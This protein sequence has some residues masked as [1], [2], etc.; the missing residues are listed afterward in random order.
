MTE[1]Q[2]ELLRQHVFDQ[3]GL[4]GAAFLLCGQSMSDESAKLIVHAVMPIDA[5]D[6][7]ERRRDGLVIKS[8]ALTRIA[9]LARNE[10][11]SIVFVHS[12]P[13]GAD[14]FSAQDDREEGRL[15]PFLQ[16]RVPGKIHGTL[17]LTK[18]SIV[19][20]L[21]MPDRQALDKTIAVGSRIRCWRA[22]SQV[23]SDFLDRQIRA[24]GKDIQSALSCLHIGI[25]G[26]G[27]TGSPVAEQLARLGV[28]MIS[29]FDGDT[30]EASN[31]NRVQG[32]HRADVGLYKVDIAK[33]NI[34]K[35]GL[36]TV[37]RAIPEHITTERSALA[38]RECDIVFGCTDKQRPRAILGCLCVAY[39][40][41]V[42]DMGVLIDSLGG[43]II[44]VHGRVTTLL[45]GEA[46][47][48]CRGRISVEG[49]RLETLSAA[50]RAGQAREGYA[51]E[52]EQ[53]APAVVTFTTAIAAL[54]VTEL[55][56]RLTGFKG[57]DRQS[58]ELLVAFDQSRMRTNRFEPHE[59]CSC[60]DQARW[61]RGDEEPFLGLAWG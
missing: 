19:G 1:A 54:A 33:R 58:S 46:C 26:L 21:Y 39:S 32:S 55:L 17:V 25:V 10:G 24:F 29:L 3:P 34:E 35:M 42:F 49:M 20:R 53:P 22:T 8:S 12:H 38:L 11:L 6:F 47:L 31:L 59:E 57:A 60:N 23:Q 40:I 13:D 36:G 56:H 43:Q 51:P 50:E 61:G 48:F 9:K 16:A 14:D 27:G 18:N 30:L 7:D 45:P 4:E 41:P 37:V 15:I 44:G 5:A 52:L 2:L 28:G